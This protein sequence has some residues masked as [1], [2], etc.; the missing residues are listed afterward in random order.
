MYL[1]VVY[2]Q[3]LCIFFLFFSIQNSYVFFAHVYEFGVILVTSRRLVYSVTL[4]L[5]NS[6]LYKEEG[7]VLHQD[8]ENKYYN[9]ISQDQNGNGN[10]HALHLNPAPCIN[11]CLLHKGAIS[12]L[13]LELNITKPS[14]IYDNL[15]PNPPPPKNRSENVASTFTM[16]SCD[17]RKNIDCE[18]STSF[19][20]P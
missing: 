17:M 11:L 15:P 12:V 3:I 1:S 5:T 10:D 20:G 7:I 14:L 16:C 8:W 2:Y 6:D 9:E 18:I 13:F 19:P 4:C